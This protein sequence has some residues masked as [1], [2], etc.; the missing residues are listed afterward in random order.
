MSTSV[1]LRIK[2]LEP[3][4]FSAQA[5]TTGGHRTLDYIPGAALLGLA[6]SRFYAESGGISD[7]IAPWSSFHSG[8]IRFGNGYPE[9]ANGDIAYPMPWSLHRPKGGGA[10]TNLAIAARAGGTQYQQLRR[11]YLTEEGHIVTVRVNSGLKTAIDAETGT[12]R[13]AMLFNNQFIEPGQNFIAR[14]EA[15]ENAAAMLDRFV[16]FL[17]GT[18]GRQHR[19]GRSRSAEFGL[20]R[21][22]RTETCPNR[23]YAENAGAVRIWCLSDVWLDTVERGKPPTAADF[24]LTAGILSAAESFI[25]FRRY[26]PFNGRWRTNA[27]E[28]V[29]I[30]A[31]S[32]LTFDNVEAG[33]PNGRRAVGLGRE[34]GL[35]EIVIDA[36]I[37]NCVQLELGDAAAPS[38]ELGAL[39]EPNSK[40]W[41]FMNNRL[42]TESR[43]ENAAAAAN[44][45][46]EQLR[47]AYERA[48]RYSGIGEN[49]LA[50]P[51]KTQWNAVAN[52]A[53]K[54]KDN[55]SLKAILFVG[56]NALIAASDADW[57]KET[58][59]GQSFR[60]LLESAVGDLAG[61]N[62]DC[63]LILN[64]AARLMAGMVE[65]RR[66][67]E[68]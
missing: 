5:I 55:A 56:E 27:P 9:T 33:Q 39:A 38:G 65:G 47:D 7:G 53:K 66:G 43:R 42:V 23:M 63:A 22:E 16:A 18:N 24:G 31:G 3:A 44:R 6:A 45:L 17:A 8:A 67:P 28:R 14:I 32:V 58:G 52:I 46:F 68:Q 49:G 35:G 59:P 62:Q 12:A 57:T 29:L 48:A 1:H 36:K 15:D 2:L 20:V 21:I 51:G 50:G 41:A 61:E 10:V 64:R 4:I 25:H 11:G 40:L 19:I 60:S 30:G 37:L 34:A 26:A 54:T 13:T